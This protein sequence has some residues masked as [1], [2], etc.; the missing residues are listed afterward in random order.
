MG[1]FENF[2]V[3]YQNRAYATPFWKP[4]GGAH[5]LIGVPGS[6]VF[7]GLVGLVYLEGVHDATLAGAGAGQ[8]YVAV[9]QGSW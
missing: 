6:A 9:K 4:A 5:P 2:P 3:E 1:V 8:A 7:F